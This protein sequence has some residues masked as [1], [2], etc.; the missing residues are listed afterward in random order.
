MHCNICT[1]DT[2]KIF[3]INEAGL[4]HSYKNMKRSYLRLIL[5]LG[6]TERVCCR[7][8]IQL[9]STLCLTTYISTIAQNMQ[10]LHNKFQLHTELLQRMEKLDRNISVA[11]GTPCMSDRR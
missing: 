11:S 4:N 8:H 1:I 7:T 10:L 9:L 2:F 5:A 3:E 6:L